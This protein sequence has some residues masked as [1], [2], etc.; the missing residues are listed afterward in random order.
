MVLAAAAPHSLP[1]AYRP[2]RN[3]A[4]GTGAAANGDGEG[5]VELP[6]GV[7]ALRGAQCR[8]PV[9]EA[10]SQRHKYTAT[11]NAAAANT[12][13]CHSRTDTPATTLIGRLF[14]LSFGVVRLANNSPLL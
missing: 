4:P 3:R 8:N 9:E 13:V 11:V 7:A 6:A 2:D 12:A 5:G 1:L 14:Y 10:M